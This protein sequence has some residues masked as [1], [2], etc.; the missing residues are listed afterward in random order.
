MRICWCGLPRVAAEFL[1]SLRSCRIVNDDNLKKGILFPLR[2]T[3]T[4]SNIIILCQET[5]RKRRFYS[6]A[7]SKEFLDHNLFNDPKVR[8]IHRDYPD[9]RAKDVRNSI[10]WPPLVSGMG[11]TQQVEG[12]HS[13]ASTH[14]KR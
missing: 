10:L 8:T 1:V 9:Y 6:L 13:C 2:H 3:I 7:M 11:I 5:F 4:V 12:K 14:T